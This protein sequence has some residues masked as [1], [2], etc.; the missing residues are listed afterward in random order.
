MTDLAERNAGP[1]LVDE[2]MPDQGPAPPDQRPPVMPGATTP[3]PFRAKLLVAVLAI[4]ALLGAAGTIIGF[5][6]G[7]DDAA[8]GT[9]ADAEATIATLT[10]E[11]LEAIDQL[12]E[13]EAD[14]EAISAERDDLLAELGVAS[15]DVAAVTSER[16]G[17]IDELDEAATE[18]DIVTAERDDA[19]A[20]ID[21]IGDRLTAQRQRATTAVTERDAL[22]ALF[23][24]TFDASLDDVDLVGTYDMKYSE[25][26]CEGFTT[27]GTVPSEDELVV[28]ETAD[29]YLRVE[30]DGIIDAG[31]FRVDGALD[32]V[33]DSTTAVPACSGTPRTAH[34]MVTM[35][36]HGLTVADDGTHRID[37]LGASIAV[38][39]PAVDGCPAG[40]A[41]YGAQ[42]TP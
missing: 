41:L 9:D 27:C 25:A 21:E 15:A 7:D 28:T 1:A 23:P 4:V 10:A 33:A 34:V 30:I 8:T 20:T 12:L 40:L 22:A 11:R 24:M 14:V 42:L 13:A 35:F 39:A 31:L 29:D 2:T 38:Q 5:T 6:T 32:A 3:W 36:A 18:L 16:D 19:L 37:D 17:L 26:Y